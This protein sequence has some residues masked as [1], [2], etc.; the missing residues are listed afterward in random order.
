ML[1][2]ACPDQFTAVDFSLSAGSRRGIAALLCLIAVA[3]PLVAQE[4]EPPSG[5]SP[6]KLT[7]WDRLIYVPFSELKKVFNNQQASAVIPYSEY[8][9]LMKVYLEKQA[10]T[11]ETTEAVIS[12][13]SYTAKVEKDV[14]RISAEY[15]IRV[16]KKEGW[17]K[18]PLTFGNVAVGKVSAADNKDVVMTGVSRGNYQILLNGAG[19]YAVTIE[20]LAAV[21]TSPESRSFAF[22]CP[23]TGISEISVTVPEPDQ[24]IEVL[25]LRVH[26]PTDGSNDR[27]TVVKASVGA[28]NSVEVRWNPR[29]GSKPV[30]DLLTSVNNTTSVSIEPGLI[31]S[32]A[33]L[34]Y[35]ILRGELSETTILIPKDARIIDV[36]SPQGRIR[37]WTPEDVGNHQRI[38]VELLTPAT[39]DFQVTVQIERNTA[40]LF[41]LVGKSDEGLLQG[42]HA[43]GV[44][45]ESGRLNV[46]T[47]SSLTSVVTGQ[48]GVKRVE[49]GG[50]AK[51][52]AVQ[53]W[54]FS[55]TTGVLILQ[56]RPVEPR[57]LVDHNTTAV[58]G[59]D[60]LT[61]T[62][63]LNYTIE[64]AGVFEVKL[65][66]PKGLTI[67][68]VRADGMSEFN[69][70]REAG[71]ITVSLTQKR[72]GALGIH[73]TAHQ[74]FDSVSA[75]VETTIATVEPQ[76]VE[77]ETGII[78]V[79]AARFLDVATVEEQTSGVFPSESDPG[80]IGRA[81]R[82]GMWKFTQ[83]P[84]TLAFR[85]SPRPSQ[86]TAT[87][88]T[89]AQVEP[90]RIDVAS[91]I[92]FHIQNAGI[93]TFRI[94]VAESLADQV[95][96]AA[97][98]PGHRIQQS[99]RATD[100]VDGWVTWT[101]VLQDE[102]LGHVTLDAT[103]IMPLEDEADA[104]RVVSIEPL[105]VLPPFA[106]DQEDRRQVTLAATQGEL[107]LLR[108]ESLSITAEGS[109]ET[110]EMV[111]VRELNLLPTEGYIAFRYF[112]QP[113]ATSITIRSHE[114]HEVVATVVSRAAF[115]VV[116]DNQR[117]AG[118]R[119]RYRITTSERQRL[120]VDLPAGVELQA[121]LLN[122]SRTTFEDSQEE[123]EDGWVARYINVSRDS[124]S[125]EEFLLTLQFRCPI[126]PNADSYPWAGRGSRQDLLLPQISGAVVQESR[127][128]VWCPEDIAF[129]GKPD[130]WSLAGDAS[131]SVWNPLVSP[132]AKVAAED[133]S[134]WIGGG[135]DG[136]FARQ[137][138]VTV[139]DSVSRVSG[140]QITWRNRPFLVGIISLGLL[141]AGFILRR[142]S[143]E[144]RLTIVL[145]GSLAMAVWWIYDSSEALQYLSAGSLAMITVAGIWLAGLLTGREEAENPGGADDSGPPTPPQTKTPAPPAPP[146]PSASSPPPA[147][148]S[149]P[150]PASGTAEPV[151][152]EPTGNE[153]PAVS[154]SPEVSQMID[155]L[156]GGKS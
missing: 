113:V 112:A 50:N 140:I 97:T 26:L 66:V 34:T 45:R 152:A 2:A 156:M 64:R 139:Y 147:K 82:I 119:A 1:S 48:S 17:A 131:W 24:T 12:E 67:D 138:N 120:R 153:A 52:S 16:L 150:S 124:A 33:T 127:L 115:E 3:G 92:G 63:V 109:G 151:S 53:S 15:N 69:L 85:T 121:P 103:W 23:V 9:E 7:T 134:V 10:Q 62:S 94:A 60:Q 68:T 133:L 28:T 43:E 51:G 37:N 56:T 125:D 143:W 76:G 145:T 5:E 58:F 84:F 90:R 149:E 32:T 36:V 95:S 100:A 55:G 13:S 14:V 41:Q 114:I 57:L 136:D 117:M 144:N 38:R 80:N 4:N 137:G 132:S 142:T 154:P 11:P 155:E 27:Q 8:M 141:A 59:D 21:K 126:T 73:I 54:E 78:D 20:L 86:V 101:I 29:A 42:I 91:Q 99:S 49:S 25:P 79:F 118:F 83:R 31:Q 18:L 47:D 19:D 88:A 22:N 130:N 123:A 135:N 61:Q 77:R 81:S 46:V 74:D 148:P 111:D 116:T 122:D 6:Q 105:R 40:E 107:R 93:D 129:V 75:D 71:Q 35:E 98:S 87:V 96:F 146:E 106:D 39:K 128:A 104:D 70:D 89:T 65:G 108:H 44:V 102:V 72:Q 30:M 110:M